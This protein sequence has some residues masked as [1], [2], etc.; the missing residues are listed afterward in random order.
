MRGPTKCAAALRMHVSEIYKKLLKQR[1]WR[2]EWAEKTGIGFALPPR[3]VRGAKISRKCPTRPTDRISQV[4][5]LLSLELLVNQRGFERP[6]SLLRTVGKITKARRHNH[7]AIFTG[8]LIG[9][10]GKSGYLPSS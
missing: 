6:A 1:E 9:K 4:G 10:S 2:L 8:P 5:K 3:A 7:L